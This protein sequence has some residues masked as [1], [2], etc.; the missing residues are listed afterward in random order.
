MTS[1]ARRR[2]HQLRSVH[3]NGHRPRP[4]RGA[5]LVADHQLHPRP[6]DADARGGSCS[7]ALALGA[8]GN[9]YL[10][11]PPGHPDEP[12]VLVRI[13]AAD[14]DD[15][16]VGRRLHARQPSASI[17]RLD[18][19]SSFCMTTAGL[20]SNA[21]FG[22]RVTIG[23]RSAVRRR[24]ADRRLARSGALGADDPRRKGWLIFFGLMMFRSPALI[25]LAAGAG[26]CASRTSLFWMVTASLAIG[27]LIAVFPSTAVHFEASTASPEHRSARATPTSRRSPRPQE[28]GV[29]VDPGVLVLGEHD[30]DRCGVRD[31]RDLRLLVDLR[32]R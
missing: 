26:R 6:P 15:P 14:A 29:N 16:A 28:A 31:D 12:L 11:T 25:Q 5:T 1:E 10:A 23:H 19:I 9:P 18:S 4:R 32:R 17:R 2:P 7:F 13:R 20:L 24:R 22:S 30:P 21:F 27:V 3:A 8:G